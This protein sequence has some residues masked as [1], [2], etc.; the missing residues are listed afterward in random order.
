MRL[1]LKYGK[2]SPELSSSLL[3]SCN[4]LNEAC[5][6]GWSMYDSIFSENGHLITD[7]C[8]KD[9]MGT[10]EK[11]SC[12]AFSKCE[13]HSKVKSSYIIGQNY[14]ATSEKNMMKEI[15]R[16]GIISVSFKSNKIF[17]KYKSGIISV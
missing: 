14:G 15:L 11:V 4:Y 8:A 9:A 1:N 17:K 16:N 13:P 6:G 5:E 3:N 2:V 12:G 10:R 7:K